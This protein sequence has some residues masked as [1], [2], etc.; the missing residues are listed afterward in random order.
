[1]NGTGGF[2]SPQKVINQ[3]GLKKDMKVADFGCGHGYFTLPV[4]KIVGQD[5]KVYA[6]DIL[7][8]ALEAV[9]SS[10]KLGGL[11]NIE[12]KRGNLETAGGS[13]LADGSVDLVLLHNVL[14][15]T[16]KKS[17]IIKEA[18]RVLK[19]GGVFVLVDW[20]KNK[21]SIGPQGGWRLSFDEARNLVQEEGLVFNRVFDAG[22]YHYGLIFIK[23]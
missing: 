4:A 15:Q 6:V 17:E 7:E 22:E 2:I 11:A 9:R 18:K 21:S 3:I 8:E 14:F 19:L 13:G 16:Q 1:M 5:G 23:P 10:Y 12:T 20:Q